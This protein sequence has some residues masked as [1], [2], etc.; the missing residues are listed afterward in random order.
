M[1]HRALKRTKILSFLII[2]ISASNISGQDYSAYKDLMKKDPAAAEKILKKSPQNNNIRISPQKSPTDGK[3]FSKNSMQEPLSRIEKMYNKRF[4]HEIQEREPLRQYGYNFFRQQKGGDS[5]LPVGRD[6]HLG[7]GD[8][9]A[10]YFWGDPVDILGLNSFYTIEVDRDGKIFL[11]SVGVY[12]VWGL[13]VDAVKKLLF[14]G[15][16][17]KFKRFEIEVT[18]GKLRT[19]PVYVS[20]FVNEPGVVLASGVC[21]VLDVLN[22][23]GGIDENG[24]MRR[25][26]LRRRSGKKKE[27]SLDLYDLLIKGKPVNFQVHEG[28]AIYVYPVQKTVGIYG[29][30]K[31]PG[32]YELNK[33]IDSIDELLKLSGGILPSAHRP[34]VKI[35]RYEKDRLN[36]LEGSL[37]D[38]S[39]LKKNCHS[40]DFVIIG[41]LY[42]KF[43]NVLVV[44]GHIAYPGRFEFKNDVSLKSI[45]E[46]AGLLPDTNRFYASIIRESTE[47]GIT[48]SPEDVLAGKKIIDLKS[49]DTIRFYPR[50]MYRPI[51]V[52]G[53]VKSPSLVSFYENITLLDAL[54]S[55]KF[56]TSVKDLKAEVYWEKDIPFVNLPKSMQRALKKTMFRPERKND[57]AMVTNKDEKL[58]SRE[59]TEKDTERN[60]LTIYLNDL[61]VKV[62]KD[63]NIL[64]PPGARILI[65][66]TRKNEKK[67]SVTILGEINKPGVYSHRPGET[68]YDC[69]VRAGGYSAN[70]FPRGL[71]F[72]RRSAQKLQE[73][74]IDMSFMSM[75]EY[76]AKQG[77]SL[78]QIGSSKEEMT[79]LQITM[80][81]YK[82]MLNSMKKRSKMAMGR[83]ALDVPLSLNELKKHPDNIRLLEGD[84]IYIPHRPNYVLV[85]GDVYNQMSL[86]HNTGKSVKYYLNQLGGLG[87]NGDENNIYVIKANGKIISKRNYSSLRTQYFAIDWKK[88][89][90]NFRYDFEDMKLE[91][92]DTIIVPSEMKVP[93]MWRPILKDIAQIMFQSM[94]T[95]ILATQL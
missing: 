85:L 84:Y 32:I 42:N 33:K 19:F 11:P 90:I 30:I 61:M 10:V 73:Q 76:V 38:T 24:S 37:N 56:K 77:Q 64:L 86:P 45:V 46:K 44:K 31:R 39:F 4:F 63:S 72:I 83:M 14:K 91:E 55:I 23:A 67:Q 69:I 25:I 82:Q 40:G 8:T 26:V 92:G 16:K 41:D 87:K 94:S 62:A 35:Y 13:K 74:Q 75:D 60:F 66:R 17:K 48:F 78:G 80:E 5:F 70:A 20:G 59:G 81:R 54:K 27:I 22:L 65:R 7:P 93:I 49:R 36:I 34:S 2:A 9:I 1:I 88:K 95:V 57:K 21:S 12:Y 53:E 15:L 43:D 6:Y 71:I 51:E 89:I 79:M 28:D 3:T 58:I 68:L 52:T 50:W 47:K 29:G 18:L